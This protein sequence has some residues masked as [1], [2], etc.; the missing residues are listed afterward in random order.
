MYRTY[1]A[2]AEE[3][4]KICITCLNKI[5]IFLNIFCMINILSTKRESAD[6]KKSKQTYFFRSRILKIS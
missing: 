2:S 6:K 3:G 4:E 1:K 5:C